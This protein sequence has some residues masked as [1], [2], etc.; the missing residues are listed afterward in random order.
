M[1]A[2]RTLLATLALAALTACSPGPGDR[3]VQAAAAQTL[4]QVDQ[5][6]KPSGLSF[7]DVFDLQVK[8]LQRERDLDS[9][10]YDGRKSIAFDL[11]DV[12]HGNTGRVGQRL[13]R[14]VK[15]SAAGPDQR[16]HQRLPR[17]QRLVRL[18]HHRCSPLGRSKIFLI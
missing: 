7:S 17:H 5:A 8:V 2:F 16:P 4:A 11:A 3:D 18:R 9:R 14:H 6:L 13:Q 1:T 12:T 15:L 10:I